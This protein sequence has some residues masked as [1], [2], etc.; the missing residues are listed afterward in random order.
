MNGQKTQSSPLGGVP[1]ALAS[2]LNAE[3]KLG[4]DLFKALTGTALPQVGDVVRSVRSRA[5]A[6]TAGCCRIPPPCWLPQSLGECTSHV[7]QCKSACIELVVTNCDA[8]QRTITVAVPQGG[9]QVTVSPASL[10]LGPYERGTV[11]VCYEAQQNEQGGSH[12]YLVWVQGCREYY[13]RW[14]VSVGTTGV[15]SCHQVTVDDCPD[16]IHHW[17]DHFYCGRQ[18]ASA[19]GTVG[20]VAT[21][22]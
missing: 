16:Y 6:S 5:S 13:L 20:G 9:T 14:T 4:S 7:G 10:D 17:Y 1:D 22:G 12:E 15:D 19:R 11:S 8:T 18:C 2:L 21:H 3:L